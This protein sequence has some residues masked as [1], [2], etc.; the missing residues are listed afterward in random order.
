MNRQPDKTIVLETRK[1][2]DAFVKRS[3]ESDADGVDILFY[4]MANGKWH[5][6]MF[7]VCGLEDTVADKHVCQNIPDT[8]SPT[9]PE[10][11]CHAERVLST[12]KLSS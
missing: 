4:Q 2:L 9:V 8:L 3:F 5:L 6:E 11:F 12:H 7:T 10:T 1:D